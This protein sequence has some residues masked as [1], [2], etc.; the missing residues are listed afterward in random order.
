MTANFPAFFPGYVP[1][2][3]FGQFWNQ[4]QQFG[5][6]FYGNVF[7]QT[8][9]AAFQGQAFGQ[10]PGQFATQTPNGYVS[11][12]VGNYFGQPT[13]QNFGQNFGQSFGQNYNQTNGQYGY[14]QF[15]WGYQAGG[16][17]AGNQ[18]TGQWNQ[19]G[20]AFHPAFG[21]YN[22][23]FTNQFNGQFA[24]PFFGQSPFGWTGSTGFGG[25]WNNSYNTPFNAAFAAPFTA[26]FVNGYGTGF[27]TQP[28][29][30]YGINTP[31]F[32]G[33]NGW[34]PVTG[35]APAAS[36]VNPFAF[37]PGAFPGAIPTNYAG[38]P[39]GYATN[40]GFTGIPNIPG[41]AGIYPTVNGVPTNVAE[42]NK[43]RN[44]GLSREVA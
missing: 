27:G 5:N 32:G 31:F 2:T 8:P 18:P 13:G 39:T 28:V 10:Y 14:G 44:I 35:F 40:P 29:Q 7:G 9:F 20:G 1:Q 16:Q 26:P 15:P 24:N 25:Q 19:F 34:N 43:A 12:A 11:D 22:G 23:Q 3:A 38:A 30:G 21:Q 37:F 42:A 17:F 6:P 36:F 4:L 33:F 41:A